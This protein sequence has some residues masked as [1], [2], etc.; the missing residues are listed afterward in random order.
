MSFTLIHGRFAIS[1]VGRDRGDPRH[2][3]ERAEL[4]QRARPALEVSVQEGDRDA[5]D[6]RKL[7]L[8]AGVGWQV[9]GAEQAQKVLRPPR[10]VEELVSEP[11]LVARVGCA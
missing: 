6:D 9:L 11:R 1:G 4:L 2:A 7:R 8:L 10:R 5:L 3:A